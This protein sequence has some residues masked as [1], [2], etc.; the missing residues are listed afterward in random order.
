M[1]DVKRSRWRAE[2]L[3]GRSLVCARCGCSVEFHAGERFALREVVRDCRLSGLQVRAIA[4]A[5]SRVADG[6]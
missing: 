5:T 4:A 6:C 1:V 3:I 2:P